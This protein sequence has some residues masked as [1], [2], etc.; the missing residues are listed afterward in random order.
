MENNEV[1]I[2][3]RKTS[4]EET[5]VKRFPYTILIRCWSLMR[6]AEEHT[7]DFFDEYGEYITGTGETTEEMAFFE[8]IPLTDDGLYSINI[9]IE[10]CVVT[11]FSIL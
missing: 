8:K 4:H 2:K 3:K 7:F 5:I 1:L 9:T 11:S 10:D 6:K